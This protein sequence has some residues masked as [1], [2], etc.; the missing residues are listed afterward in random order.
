MCKKGIFNKLDFSLMQI[1]NGKFSEV[2]ATL[3]N[4]EYRC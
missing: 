2:P 4:V 1:R 3:E